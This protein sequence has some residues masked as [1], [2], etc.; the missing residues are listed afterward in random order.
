MVSG[1]G[2]GAV[3]EDDCLTDW[4]T[5]EIHGNHTSP[6]GRHNLRRNLSPA[7]RCPTQIHHQPGIPQETMLLVHLQQFKSRTA[8]IAF[9]LGSL[10]PWVSSV[11]EEPLATIPPIHQ[12]ATIA[13]GRHYDVDFDKDDE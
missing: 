10:Y 6:S 11:P 7:S 2:A 9:L 1:G 13:S 4:H 8:P 3:A 5:Q 12:S